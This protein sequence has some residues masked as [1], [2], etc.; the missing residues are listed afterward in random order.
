M[1]KWWWTAMV[2]VSVLAS[3]CVGRPRPTVIFPTLVT[4][5]GTPTPIPTGAPT[6]TPFPTPTKTPT[7]APTLTPTPLPPTPTKTPTPTP[8]AAGPF[9]LAVTKAVQCDSKW[10]CAITLTVTNNG[11]GVYSG[12]LVVADQST[13][14]W[15]TLLSGGG[16]VSGS[17]CT[18]S[19]NT[20][21][22]SQP[23]GGLGPGGSATFVLGVYFGPSGYTQPFQNCAS[24]QGITDAQPAND[25]TCVSAQ[26]P[27]PTPTPAPMPTPTPTAPSLSCVISPAGLT[28]W[29]RMD[30]PAG[31]AAI[32]EAL[33]AHPGTPRS[34]AGASLSVV[35]GTGPSPRVGA[36]AGQVGGALFFNGAYGQVPHAPA[37][38]LG[39]GGLTIEGWVRTA[40]PSSA[41][42]LLQP[43]VDKTYSVS[44]GAPIP[45]GYSL[46]LQ[47]NSGAGAFDLV[48]RLGTGVGPGYLTVAT[49]AVPP[50]Q[51]VFVAAVAQP[52]SPGTVTLY[53]NGA[54]VATGS[55]S[56]TPAAV[57]NTEDLWLAGQH[58]LAT[59]PATFGWDLAMDEWELWGRALSPSEITA[60]YTAGLGGQPKC[61]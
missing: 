24:L 49:G 42:P 53:V 26:P 10:T 29:W 8:A 37:L 47:W 61:R 5:T 52:G 45:Q 6:S 23:S 18:M 51:K 57:A 31:S 38:N 55:V 19:G 30:D 3:A 50:L 14:P 32:A 28:A 44:P 12:P 48:F 41:T 16:S 35:A 20:V 11:P 21:L 46:Y 9:D 36:V 25:S 4:L 2:L 58:P 40:G 7:V 59:S 27:G 1:K 60:L 43:L 34:A 54:A 13:P 17:N 56:F 22:C 39:T 15:S 33:G